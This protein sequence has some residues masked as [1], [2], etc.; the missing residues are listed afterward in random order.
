M[1]YE[2]GDVVTVMVMNVFCLDA[3]YLD[4]LLRLISLCKQ[5]NLHTEK[6]LYT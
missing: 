6:Q 4:L 1:R 5:V 3:L 2:F